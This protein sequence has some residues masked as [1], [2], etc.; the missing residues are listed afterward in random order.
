MSNASRRFLSWPIFEE[1]VNSFLVQP[2]PKERPK[3]RYTNTGYQF[4]IPVDMANQPASII[5]SRYRK[6]TAHL[7][8]FAVRLGIDQHYYLLPQGPDVLK[9]RKQ[10]RDH[11]KKGYIKL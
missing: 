9:L 4:Q 6:G 3:G 8:T 5:V 2:T 10:L 7:Y 11:I 1:L